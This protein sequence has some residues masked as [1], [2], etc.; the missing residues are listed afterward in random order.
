[1][2]ID[3]HLVRDKFK[4]GLLVPQHT[5]STHQSA[6][7]FT[8]SLFGSLFSCFLTKLGMADSHHPTLILGGGGGGGGGGVGEGGGVMGDDEHML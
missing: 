2:E 5:S 4:V 7:I 8:K 3:C 6:D 1:M